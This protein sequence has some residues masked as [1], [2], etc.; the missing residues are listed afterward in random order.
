MAKYEVRVLDMAGAEKGTI[1][2]FQSLSILD[3]AN[4]CGSWKIKSRTPYRQPFE[5]YGFALF[6]RDGVY[7]FGGPMQKFSETYDPVL[8][9]WEW[10]AIGYGFNALLKDV[11]IY[12][13][14]YTDP[15]TDLQFVNRYYTIS[16]YQS[17]TY[18]I[19]DLI[20]KNCS[21]NSRLNSRDK[22][23]YIISGAVMENSVESSPEISYR[24]DNLLQA[25]QAL[26]GSY[27]FILPYFDTS[28]RKVTYYVTG[29]AFT[30]PIVFAADTL[31]V[32][33]Y[34]HSY[35]TPDTTALVMSYNADTA[36]VWKDCYEKYLYN[37]AG[38]LR[39]VLYKPTNEQLGGIYDRYK[40]VDVA[41][42]AALDY[43][44]NS[45]GMEITV[46]PSLYTYG[47]D[48]ENGSWVCDYKMGDEVK[49]VLP[50]EEFAVRVRQM[51]F[52]V[53]YGKETITPG[54]G[55]ITKG[56]FNGIY[57]NLKNVN[58]SVTKADT[59]EIT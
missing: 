15:L 58:I 39:E 24:F 13:S 2:D 29:R 43:I 53:S 6:Y 30:D 14:D 59:E 9:S 48:R 25:C 16:Q 20:N 49:I 36:N 31:G 38:R 12:P 50:D 10:E 21:D 55:A 22:P 56:A 17:A 57:N 35:D 32:L 41:G 34:K 26:T 28:T 18:N 51:K 19:T 4:D 3:A 54:F 37:G 44:V 45:E 33:S 46:D 52:E 1:L 47:Y 11:L 40:L 5:P 27:I 23:C 7:I 8:K 42:K